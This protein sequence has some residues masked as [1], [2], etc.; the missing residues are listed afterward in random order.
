MSDKKYF[1]DYIPGN[2]CFGCGRDNHEGLKI[3]SYWDGDEAICEF[4]SDP[5]YQGW[6]NIM[7]G[8]IIAT[9]IDC[10][11]MCTA[12]AHAYKLEDRDLGSMPQYKYATGT[13]T[14]KYL[15]PTPN[16]KPLTLKARVTEQKGKKST[17]ECEVYVDGV[18]TA[19]ANVIGIRV[20]S[21]AEE[22]GIFT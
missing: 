21:S 9:L 2:I 13:L 14:V 7:N 19:E 16:N 22:K 12:A 4:N 10:H 5:R 18:K 1:Q 11:T 17:I 8:G 6:K 20:Y 3:S 15:K